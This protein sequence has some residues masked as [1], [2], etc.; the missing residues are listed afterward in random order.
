MKL[1]YSPWPNSPSSTGE[2]RG[3]FGDPLNPE[4]PEAPAPIRQITIEEDVEKWMAWTL[5]NFPKSGTEASLIHLQEEIKEILSELQSDDPN[6]TSEEG[7]TLME[8]A[9]A[10]ICLFT[11]AGKS[12]FTIQEIFRAVKNK[13]E[14]NYKRKWILNPDNTYSHVKE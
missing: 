6:P 13:M 1:F 10:F 9:D 3:F 14:I 7:V 8:F 12:G 2:P 5:A 11:A 4:K